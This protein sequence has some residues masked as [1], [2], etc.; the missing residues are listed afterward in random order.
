MECY[1]FAISSYILIWNRLFSF[2]KKEKKKKKAMFGINFAI[3]RT[4]KRQKR[5]EKKRKHTNIIV[6][7]WQLPL[8]EFDLICMLVGTPRAVRAIWIYFLNTIIL[9]ILSIYIV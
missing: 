3:R 5:K 6:E 9:K 8:I 1:Y 2:Q 7:S 4:R